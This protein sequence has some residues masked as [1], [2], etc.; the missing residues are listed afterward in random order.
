MPP[1][2]I[3]YVGSARC[4]MRSTTRCTMGGLPAAAGVREAEGNEIETACGELACPEFVEEVE[5]VV[6][7]CRG[8]GDETMF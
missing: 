3:V 8:S 5:A 7:A 1:C 2:A 6:A 4:T